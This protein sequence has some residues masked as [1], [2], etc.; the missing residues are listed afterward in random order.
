[1][2]KYTDNFIAS[3]SDEITKTFP[4]VNE[5]VPVGF[6]RYNG[7]DIDAI[8]IVVVYKDGHDGFVR[9]NVEKGVN[10]IQSA[11]YEVDNIHEIR[12]DKEGKMLCEYFHYYTPK[13]IDVMKYID[14]KLVGS[15][16]I[17]Y[18][19]IREYKQRANQLRALGII[20]KEENTF[21]CFD[22]DG[23]NYLAIGERHG[24]S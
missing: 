13:Q 14:N 22:K 19:D 1:M 21:Q 4:L 5:I 2:P 12:V 23:K 15:Y 8:Y 16:E 9:F 20:E 11:Y 6:I 17:R 24:N 7:D 10:Y 3:V 18:D